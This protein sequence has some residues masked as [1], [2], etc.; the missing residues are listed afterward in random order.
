[1]TVRFALTFDYLC[2][3][4]RIANETVA[5]A[6]EDGVDWD[7]EFRPFSPSGS[8]STPNSRTYGTGNRGPPGPGSA[9]PA[10]GRCGT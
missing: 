8:T 4:A 5:E 7:V 6:I 10:V 2:P 9:R 3:F 1:M